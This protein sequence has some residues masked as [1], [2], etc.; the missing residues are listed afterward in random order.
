MPEIY[1]IKKNIRSGFMYF[2]VEVYLLRTFSC[3]L[4]KKQVEKRL[5]KE[6]AFKKIF[7]LESRVEIGDSGEIQTSP[8]KLFS[9]TALDYLSILI[10]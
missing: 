10:I 4:Y 7:G 8:E 6:L 3:V 1:N 9:K 5:Y 2:T